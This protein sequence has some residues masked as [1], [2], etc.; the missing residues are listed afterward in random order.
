VITQREIGEDTRSFRDSLRT[1]L[2]QDPD[3]IMVGEIRD[4]ETFDTA[5]RAAE[6][7]HLVMS[8]IHTTDVQKTIGRILSFY[9]AEEHMSLR[10]RLADNLGA[11]VSLRLLPHKSGNG[12]VPAVEIMRTTHTLQECIKNPEK[13]QEMAAHMERGREPYG[14]QTFDQHL[15]QLYKESKITLQ[16]AKAAASS[17]NEFDRLLTLEGG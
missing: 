7:G 6:T 15:L 4:G 9:P 17:V 13:T 10:H 16:V 5:L 12:R 8:A 3:V 1:A 11:I 14:M 2:R